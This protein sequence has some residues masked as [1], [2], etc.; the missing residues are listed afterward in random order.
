MADYNKLVSLEAKIL[1]LESMVNHLP[2]VWMKQL[3]DQY[4]S[5][6]DQLLKEH[7]LS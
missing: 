3:K 2:E 7:N 1:L 6:Y 5:E 4:Q